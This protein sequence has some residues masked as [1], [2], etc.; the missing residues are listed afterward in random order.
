[1][2]AHLSER[3]SSLSFHD[4]NAYV[5]NDNIPTSGPSRANN[6]IRE[7][8]ELMKKPFA[9]GAWLN[10]PEIPSPSEVMSQNNMY[11]FPNS[12]PQLIDVD[13]L[14]P[15]KPEGAYENKEEYLSIKYELLRED[16]IKDFRACIEE[17]SVLRSRFNCIQANIF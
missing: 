8:F 1:M 17:V 2:N 14:R 13:G 3:L 12:E 10:R 4:N 16:C 15:H 9:G 5:P 11:G 6:D 7:Y